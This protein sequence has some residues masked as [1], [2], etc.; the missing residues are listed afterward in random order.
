MRAAAAAAGGGA[1]SAC[2][3]AGCPSLTAPPGCLLL[4]LLRLAAGSWA[5]APLDSTPGE[6]GCVAVLQRP[7]WSAAEQ[8]PLRQWER[9]PVVV[10]GTQQR[11]SA[12][13]D[14][15]R[16]ERQSPRSPCVQ[17]AE[18]P[19]GIPWIAPRWRLRPRCWSSEQVELLS[20]KL[21]AAL[22]AFQ[23]CWRLRRI[24]APRMPG[25]SRAGPRLAAYPPRDL[26]QEQGQGEAACSIHGS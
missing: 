3:G 26:E 2:H 4:L 20:R 21:R 1:L 15:D 22:Q 5:R 23:I 24:C 16:G 11:G 12:P 25:S 14:E 18:G 6:P 8:P 19:P 7:R 10:P 13:L 9:L 17:T